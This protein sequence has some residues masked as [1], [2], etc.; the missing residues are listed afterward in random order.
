MKVVGIDPAPSF[1]GHI[2]DGI[3]RSVSAAELAN[4]LRELRTVDSSLVCWDAPLSG[5]A[6]PETISGISG[7]FTKRPIERFFTQKRWEFKVPEGISMLPYSGCA[8]WT[9][10]RHLLGLPRVGPWD[11]PLTSLPFKLVTNGPPTEPGHYIVEVHPALALWLWCGFGPNPWEGP[12]TYKRKN[13][14]DIL[15]ELW[16]LLCERLAEQD[17]SDIVNVITAL[18][19]P[20]SDDDL[21]SRVAWLLGELWLSRTGSVVQLGSATQGSFLL[22]DVPGLIEAFGRFIHREMPPKQR[23]QRG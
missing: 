23:H 3:Y 1:G 13:G 20:Q 2:F 9:I 22:P 14:Y 18:G 17:A 15:V 5:P 16:D 4:L 21:D 8:H 10:S 19:T 11:M 12:W 6:T 7:E